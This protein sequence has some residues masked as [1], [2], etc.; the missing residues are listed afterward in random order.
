MK[1]AHLIL[2]HAAP[3]QLTRLVKRLW[4]KDA[5]FFIHL[6]SKA[7][8]EPFSELAGMGHVIFVQP[9][10]NVRW[11]AYSIVQ[12]TINGFEAIHTSGQKYDFVNLLSGADYPLRSTQYIHDFF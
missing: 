11:G 5:S 2:A 4:H 9:R 8:I 7:D 1:I 10:I 6:D 3:E 12:A